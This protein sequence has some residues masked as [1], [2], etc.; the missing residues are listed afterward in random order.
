MWYAATAVADDPDALVVPLATAKTRLRIDTS[1]DD[2]LLTDL[3]REAGAHAARYCNIRLLP[4]EL[5]AHCDSFADMVRL[6]DGPVFAGA[7]QSIAYVDGAGVDQVLDPASY[8]LRIDGLEAAIL[9]RPGGAWPVA[10]HGDLITLTIKAGYGDGIPFE[11]QAAI[12]VRVATAYAGGENVEA[13]KWTEFDTLL[14]NF[15]RGA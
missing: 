8:E 6:P 5:V 13:G 12:L 10:R 1:D 3:L 11:I 9:P 7:V 15:K 14:V 4:Q 2:A